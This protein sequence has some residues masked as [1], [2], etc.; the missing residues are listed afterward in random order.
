[1]A[2]ST[3]ITAER[4]ARLG[5][6]P[7]LSAILVGKTIAEACELYLEDLTIVIGSAG[8]TAGGVVTYTL[9]GQTVTTSME[10]ASRLR[11]FLIQMKNAG[12]GPSFLKVGLA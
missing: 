3:V 6:S 1:M 8:V 9:E 10:E 7:T 11:R 4:L 2:S 12:G 5:I